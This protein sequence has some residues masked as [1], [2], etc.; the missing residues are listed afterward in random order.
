M[1]DASG[2]KAFLIPISERILVAAAKPM[3]KE[4]LSSRSSGSSQV[5]VK[6]SR[7]FAV[8]TSGQC[9]RIPG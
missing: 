3:K 9:F 7:A 1:A 8:G 5:D 4:E 2:R 6:K